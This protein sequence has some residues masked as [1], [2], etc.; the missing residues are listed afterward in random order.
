[1]SKR[2]KARHAII[3]KRK[4]SEVMAD[5][6]GGAVLIGTAAMF[7][8]PAGVAQAAT[9]HGGQAGAFRS[10]TTSGPVGSQGPQGGSGQAPGRSSLDRGTVRLESQISPDI[11]ATGQAYIGPQGLTGPPGPRG[12]QGFRGPQGYRGPTGPRGAR[13]FTGTR[14]ARGFTGRRGYPGPQ[15]PQGK[16]G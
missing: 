5:L 13:G 14:G 16:P 10:Q 11:D 7:M 3:R 9:M 8:S 1:M 4:R 15:G 2:G 12:P 6:A